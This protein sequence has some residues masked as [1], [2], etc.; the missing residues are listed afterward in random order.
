MVDIAR[1]ADVDE[2]ARSAAE[3]FVGVVSGIQAAGGGR[4]SDGVA[5]V[6]LTGG[7]AGIKLLENLRSFHEAAERQSETFPAQRIDW[8]RVEIFFGDERNV[9][10]THPDSNEG[11]A[12]TALLDH[13]G[14][15]DESIH[16]YELG[17][18]EL[19]Q[20]AADYAGVLGEYAP[21]GF[22]IHLLGVGPEGHINT[23][24][25]H[26]QAVAEKDQLVVAEFDSPKPPPERATLTL[27]AVQRAERVWLLV[28]G[29]DKTEAAA[30]VA[31]RASPDEWPAAGAEGSAET[32]MF[33]AE[34]AAA[35]VDKL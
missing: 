6:V 32:V 28:A 2:L 25:P 17:S 15:A 34:D 11:Q 23:L 3:K 4:H 35:D 19:T 1:Q 7:G 13:V 30:A 24:F 31:R 27:P 22:D 16:S 8:T 21:Q 5:R 26:T 9:E 29:E 20:G 33:L 12:R 10:V 18:K 14:I